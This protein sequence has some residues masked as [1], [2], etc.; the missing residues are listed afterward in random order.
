MV[1]KQAE[2]LRAANEELSVQAE[3][4]QVANEELTIQTE[5]LRV[6]NEELAA[7]AEILTHQKE[8]LEH[9]ARELDTE[10]ALLESVLDQMPASVVIVAAPAGPILLSNRRAE[11]IWRQPLGS[12]TDLESFW[13]MPRYSPDSQAYKKE[14]MPLWRSLTMGEVV[15]DEEYS[16]QPEGG[17]PIHLSVSSAPVRDDQGRIVAGVI[18]HFDITARKAAEAEIR[19]LASF[20]QLNPNP[21][22]EID[23][24]G[25]I[26]YYNLATLAALEASGEAA[27]PEAFFPQDL[28][29]ILIA[30]RERGEGRFYREVRLKDA[31]FAEDISYIEPLKVFR[32]YA[33]DITARKAAELERQRLLEGLQENREELQVI[34]EELLAQTEELQEANRDLLTAQ[35]A[36]KASEARFRGLFE[37][38]TEGV[39]LHEIM[40]DDQDRAV[41]YRILATNPAFAVQ[42]GLDPEQIEGQPARTAYGTAEAPF[43]ETYARVAQTGQSV[44]FET[45]FPPIK[46]HFSISA[47]SPQPGQ[48]VTVFEDITARKAA[49]GERELVIRILGLVNA[50]TSLHELTREVTKVLQEWSG[51]EAVGIRLRQGEDF[52]YFETRGFPVKFVEMENSLC[53]RNQ[54][55][56]LRRDGAGNAI[57]ECMCGNVICGRFNPEFTFFTP[58]GS[59]W[60]NS[61]TQLLAST[62]EKDRQARTRNRCHGEGYE[63]VALVPLKSGQEALGLLQF[64]D[65]TQGKFT[66]AKIQLVERLA[67]NLASGIAI[68]Q[69]EEAMRESEERYRSL[70]EDNHAVMLLINPETGHIMDANPAACLYYGY[71]REELLT[72]KITDINILAPEEVYEEM[73]RAKSEQRKHFEFRH[74]LAS[75]EIREVEVFSGP[76]RIKGRELLYSIVHDNMARKQAEEALRRSN[77]SLDLLAETAGLLL[78]SASPQQVVDS[79]CR[80]VMSFL[81]CD[82]FFNFLADEEEGRLH[83]NAYAGIPAEEAK[84]IEWLDFGVAVCGC[85]ARDGRRIVTEQIQTTPDPRTELVKSYGVQAYAAHPLLMQGRVLGTLSFG[86]RRRSRFT[87]DDLALMKA[88]ADQVAVAMDRK[89]AEGT[90]QA[91]EARE[92]ARAAELQAVLEAVPVPIFLGGDAL[93]RVITGNPAASE[94]L[95]MPIGANYS[96]AIQEDEPPPYRAIKDGRELRLEELPVQRAVAGQMVRD[97]EYDLVLADGTVRHVSANAVPLWDE[98]GRPRGAV[99]AYLD[100]TEW[101]QAQEALKRGRGELEERVRE[102]TAELRDT[103]AQLIEE[104]QERQLAQVA[105]RKQAELLDLAHEAIMVRDL[106]SRITFWNRGAAE[107]YGWTREQAL[108]QVSRVLLKTQ[109]PTSWGEIDRELLARGQWQGELVHTRADGE[110][111]VVA[112]RMALQRDDQGQPVAILEIDRD[113]TARRQAEEALKNERQRLFAVLERIPAHVALLRPDHTF[114]YVNGEFLR[115]FGEPGS[116]RCYEL[117]GR[118][119]PCAECQAMEI[120]HTEKPVVWEWTGPDGNI[121]QMYDYPF[122]DVDGSPLALELGVDI[123]PRKR[124]EDQAVSLGRM[125]RMVSKV[126]EAI[127]RVAAKEELFRQICRI[128]MTEGDFLLAWIGLVDPETRLVKAATQYDLNDDYVQN[129]TIPYDDSPQGRG[130]TGVA[131]REGR[132]DV[133]N[134]IAS[135]PRMAP[136]RE[137]GLARGFR[138]SA[139]FPLRVGSHVVG[140]LTVYADRPGFFTSEETDLL[141]SLAGDLSFALD[142]M[143]REVKRRQAEGALRESEERLRYLASQLLHAQENER[144]RVALEL[145]DDL[146]QAL[147]VLKLQLRAIERTV[148]SDQWRTREECS[149]SLEYLNGVIDNVRRLS[150]NLRPAVLEDLGLSAGLRSL[151]EEFLAYHEIDISLEMDDIE[152]LFSREEEIN[153]YRIFQETLTN[154]AKHAQARRVKLVIK[155]QADSVIFKVVDDGVGF[156]LEQVLGR[157]PATKGLGLA[158]LEERVHMLGGTQT[159]LTQERRGTEVSFTVPIMKNRMAE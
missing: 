153:I 106:D 6:Q 15:L 12:D 43:L 64:N 92:R 18:T 51:C 74:R 82:V 121:Y 14:Q 159:I 147:M 139:A 88:V 46:R 100:L 37:H 125:Y 113:V 77:Q 119:N 17:P 73:E 138:S 95:H 21:V 53:A 48:F 84:K 86:T 111:I 57:M 122:I 141:E 107:T 97:F 19:R 66:R 71:S 112:S 157:D 127:V 1:R 42:T 34:N 32:I 87:A 27:R 62:G 16:L 75:G 61:T 23:L 105:S 94:L 9:L 22:L 151:T 110:K 152:G 96:K 67:D 68:R 55:G 20:P 117:V 136:W 38:M 143:D 30:G 79:L 123:T 80:K 7:Q 60:T 109:F 50:P 155:R 158:A 10:R 91:S 4:L 134:D 93:G 70:F 128:M 65:R 83:L 149:H 150:R 148:P 114:A 131:V 24:A 39:A 69:A 35:I 47:T 137:P 118:Q 130:P 78:A 3:E 135:D 76:L 102:R 58:G 129:I 45:F 101:N 40:F 156:D 2:E 26:T 13:R 108:G 36:L 44:S 115:R 85:A 145:H 132:Y 72:K 31:V 104:V 25:A 144:R 49:E 8:E 59:F 63:S 146:G 89:L 41:D 154:I 98:A 56:Q 52:P 142:F 126:N 140:V 116:K 33:R 124:A 120:F 54:A 99:A 133:C 29:H 5:E 11:E 90:L 103:V 28:E 81:D